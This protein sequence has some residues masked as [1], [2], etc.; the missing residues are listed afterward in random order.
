MSKYGKWVLTALCA[1]WC[2]VIFSFSLSPAEASAET[3]GEVLGFYHNFQ[4]SFPFLPTL[5]GRTVRKM[6]HFMEFLVLGVLASATFRVHGFSHGWLMA[7]ASVL[8][9][10]TADEI[11]QIFVPGRGP[12][13]RDV[14]LD[15]AGGVCGILLFYG[16][17]FLAL[18]IKGKKTE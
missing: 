3:S 18:Y 13:V 1:F 10:A 7:P 2:L 8:L 4:K 16:L 5:T 11:I 14:L 6:A 9:V 17:L 15:F 12:H